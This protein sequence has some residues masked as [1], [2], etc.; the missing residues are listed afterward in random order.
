MARNYTGTIQQRSKNLLPSADRIPMGFA[1]DSLGVPSPSSMAIFTQPHIG[2]YSADVDGTEIDKGDST[3]Q[4]DDFLVA[5]PLSKVEHTAGYKCLAYIYG[6]GGDVGIASEVEQLAAL[7]TTR[8]ENLKQRHGAA[9]LYIGFDGYTSINTHSIVKIIKVKAVNGILCFIFEGNVPSQYPN[10]TSI[11]A[12]YANSRDVSKPN[13]A[14]IDYGNGTEVG[15]DADGGPVYGELSRSPDLTVSTS[16]RVESTVLSAAPTVAKYHKRTALVPIVPGVNLFKDDS[17]QIQ[18]K[19]G[20]DNF[21]FPQYHYLITSPGRQDSDGFTQP[22]PTGFTAPYT[23][24]TY[25]CLVRIS[26]AEYDL[27][28]ADDSVETIMG[29]F[30]LTNNLITSMLANMSIHFDGRSFVILKAN[31]TD[32]KRVFTFIGYRQVI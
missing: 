19:I 4:N 25:P 30:T 20:Y 1:D 6:Q 7:M 8:V 5:V 23:G 2:Q 17:G 18:D 9:Y 28:G 3:P 22:I 16:Q 13:W 29:E 21:N 11:T 14:F 10:A 24:I 27:D 32:N 26:E 31:T 15:V 12:I